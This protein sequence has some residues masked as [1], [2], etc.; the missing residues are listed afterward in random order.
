MRLTVDNSEFPKVFIEHNKYTPFSV[1]VSK[2][3]LI[4]GINV[5]GAGPDDIV[6]GSFEGFAPTAPDTGIQQD[7]HEADSSGGGSIRS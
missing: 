6:A 7:L 1:S 2:D 5:P 3:F 4:T